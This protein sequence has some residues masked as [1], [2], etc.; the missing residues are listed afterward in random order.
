MFIF[1][2]SQIFLNLLLN[3]H[4]EISIICLVKFL[5]KKLI[6]WEWKSSPEWSALPLKLC[7]WWRKFV[8]EILFALLNFFM[9]WSLIFVKAIP[10]SRQMI[11]YHSQAFLQF[12]IM[13]QNKTKNQ[14]LFLFVS[15]HILNDRC[16]VATCRIITHH[17]KWA[18]FSNLVSSLCTTLQT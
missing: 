14:T 13:S 18:R 2:K 9:N 6:F 12:Y 5:S 8:Q 11:H 16:L 10:G 3:Y 1:L 17:T 15:T 7:L 4:N